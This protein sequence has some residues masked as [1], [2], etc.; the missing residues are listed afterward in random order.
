MRMRISFLEKRR[1][2]SLANV[3]PMATVDVLRARVWGDEMRRGGRGRRTSRRLWRVVCL[4]L[5]VIS[6][7][8][9]WVW[10]CGRGGRE[11]REGARRMREGA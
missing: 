4:Y 6:R 10:V 3:M 1:W 2:K 11:T 5:M 9:Y 7:F 8:V